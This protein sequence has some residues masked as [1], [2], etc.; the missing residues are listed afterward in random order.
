ML[1]DK[2][3]YALSLLPFWLIFVLGVFLGFGTTFV[4]E[5]LFKIIQALAAI[6]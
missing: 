3:E 4:I 6:V 1:L 5:K 2:I